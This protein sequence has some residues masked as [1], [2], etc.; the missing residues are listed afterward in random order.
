MHES[1]LYP[2][3]YIKEER[4]NPLFI[5]NETVISD[6]EA[7][8]LLYA[9]TDYRRG[10][11]VE[12]MGRLAS[13]MTADAATIR[14]RQNII[15]DIIENDELYDLLDG[16]Y[17]DLMDIN[18]VVSS[19][20]NA[21]DPESRLYMI[22]ELSLFVKC[23]DAIGSYFSRADTRLNSEGLI[24]FRDSI[25]GFVQ[26]TE[27]KSLQEGCAKLDTSFT[28]A[29]SI[30]IGANLDNKLMIS[31]AGIVSVNDRP[32]RSGKLIDKMF[33][34]EFQNDEF[35]TIVPL[36]PQPKG[37]SLT[38][39]KLN[40]G[41][42]QSLN[43][44]YSKNIS[45]L[46][47]AI[48][49]YAAASA[50]IL[51]NFREISFYL[52]AVKF[53]KDIQKN[54]LSMCAPQIS[55]GNSQEIKGIYNINFALVNMKADTMELNPDIKVVPNDIAFDEAS[56][57]YILTGPNSGGKTLFLQAVGLA[58]ILFQLGLFVPAQNAV[59]HPVDA[60]LT[61]FANQ[62][63]LALRTGK[64]G[65]ECENVK[66]LLDKVTGESLVLI[67]EPF[68]ST[69]F[70]EGT[71]LCEEI[72]TVLSVVGAMGIIVSHFHEL[73]EKAES[74]NTGQKVK[75]RVANLVAGVSDE[76]DEDG[77]RKRTFKITRG[78]PSFKSYAKDIAMRY[79]INAQLV[80]EN[81]KRGN[82]D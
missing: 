53:I 28:H 41:I 4:F 21:S 79:G 8:R 3:G 30:T 39:S 66:N 52:S 54:G 37:E 57:I 36:A 32:Y 51:M 73:A 82:K 75:S 71:L 64:L 62:E 7:K 31:E 23:A 27:Y 76:L 1:L 6:I 13:L 10:G 58:Q 68:A 2:P 59:M 44:I 70:S 29:Q 45:Q 35:L 20:N 74:Y 22:K 77:F 24:A 12:S 48:H 55:D 5:L 15:K 69:S 50:Q 63:D 9:I 60:V 26:S 67:N 25:R 81:K 65:Q 19:R 33:R 34:M 16:I 18:S 80:L 11:D 46:S 61:H 78:T 43:E 72:I 42:L 56:R 38:N 17:F 14:Y 49:N 40:T 47:S